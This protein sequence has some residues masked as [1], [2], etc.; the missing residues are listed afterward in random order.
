MKK[1]SWTIEYSINFENSINQL[2]LQISDSIMHF[3]LHSNTVISSLRKTCFNVHS[4]NQ[5][6]SK[7]TILKSKSAK[8][9]RRRQDESYSPQIK[10]HLFFI[11]LNRYLYNLSG[12]WH[13]LIPNMCK[14][15]SAHHEKCWNGTHLTG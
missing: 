12:F 8:P 9:R 1:F 5:K 3:K 10:M 2:R 13:L 4:T 15:I 6:K 7:Y 11:E 14:Q